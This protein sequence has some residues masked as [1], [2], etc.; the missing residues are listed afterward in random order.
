MAKDNKK[1]TMEQHTAAR[2]SMNS[3]LLVELMKHLHDRGII[4]LATLAATMK[5]NLGP[6]ADQVDAY[7]LG[8]VAMQLNALAAYPAQVKGPSH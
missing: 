7:T 5:E 6:I 3:F 8:V 4:D 2:T 1:I